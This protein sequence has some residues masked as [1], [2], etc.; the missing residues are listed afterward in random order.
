MYGVT[1]EIE[2][3]INTY[4]FFISA[5][6]N[7]CN[8]YLLHGEESELRNK[9][10]LSQSRNYPNFMELGDSLPHSQMSA[11]CPYP[12]LTRSSPYPHIPL[13]EVPS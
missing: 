12:E 4:Q 8:T 11:H 9:P 6:Q 13:P 7:D 1:T 3:K 10:F 2:K 5:Q